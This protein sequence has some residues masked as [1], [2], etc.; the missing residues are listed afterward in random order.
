MEHVPI[1][2]IIEANDLIDFDKK[3]KNKF[4]QDQIEILAWEYISV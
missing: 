1:R 4:I 3:I 2:L